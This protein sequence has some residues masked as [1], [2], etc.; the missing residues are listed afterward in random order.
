MKTDNNEFIYSKNVTTSTGYMV[1]QG[2]F[3]SNFIFFTLNTNFTAWFM[4]S[5]DSEHLFQYMYVVV[6]SIKLIIYGTR[7]TFPNW[8]Q[9][10]E[11]LLNCNHFKNYTP[12][13]PMII[14]ATAWCIILQVNSICRENIAKSASVLVIKWYEIINAPIKI[15]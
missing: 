5:I 2:F 3:T 4:N 14:H 11:S 15:W 13:K 9:Y 7:S 12:S 8:K 6:I 1:N 10:A